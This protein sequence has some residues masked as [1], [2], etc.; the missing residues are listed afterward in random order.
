MARRSTIGP[1][2][3]TTGTLIWGAFG[4]AENNTIAGLAGPNLVV[5]G[6]AALSGD[7]TR[8]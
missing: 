8:T 3:T 6:S 2:P 7:G 5:T 1:G 4:V